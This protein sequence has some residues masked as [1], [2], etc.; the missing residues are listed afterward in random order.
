MYTEKN[1]ADADASGQDE[2]TDVINERFDDLRERFSALDA[3]LRAVAR[4]RPLVVLG[5]ALVLGY[6]VGRIVSR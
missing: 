5:G 4:E 2:L 6:I 1:I 3:R